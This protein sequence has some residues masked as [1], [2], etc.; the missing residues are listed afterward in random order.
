MIYGICF[1]IFKRQEERKGRKEERKEEG[2]E[3][4][5]GKHWW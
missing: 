2:R 5:K 1:K 3:E 4:G